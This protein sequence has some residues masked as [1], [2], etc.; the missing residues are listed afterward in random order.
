MALSLRI[1]HGAVGAWGEI[2][3]FRFVCENRAVRTA[4]GNRECDRFERRGGA[5]L[6]MAAIAAQ[7]RSV[8]KNAEIINRGYENIVNKLRSVGADIIENN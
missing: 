7:G 4:L 6:L 8:I 3:S 5:A 2:Y 1:S